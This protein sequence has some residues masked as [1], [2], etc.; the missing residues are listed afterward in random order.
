MDESDF[1][2]E[3]E[4]GLN[5]WHG[6]DESGTTRPIA[7]EDLTQID[8][9]LFGRVISIII[10]NGYRTRKQVDKAESTIDSVID[11]IVSRRG[12]SLSLTLQ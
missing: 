3:E 6:E 12:L 11:T 2:C 1:E 5:L 7:W 8:K 4:S 9:T 10:D